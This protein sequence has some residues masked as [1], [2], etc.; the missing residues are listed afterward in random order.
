[1]YANEIVTEHMFPL[2]DTSLVTETAFLRCIDPHFR[3][4][5]LYINNL[6][7]VQNDFVTI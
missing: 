4:I 3:V 5:G 2:S 1:M 7:T 6:I